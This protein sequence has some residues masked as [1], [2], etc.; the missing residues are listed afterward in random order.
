MELIF[1]FFKFLQQVWLGSICHFINSGAAGS[2]TF[3]GN[4]FVDWIDTYPKNYSVSFLGTTSEIGIRPYYKYGNAEHPVFYNTGGVRFGDDATDTTL[5]RER[6]TV[7][8][9]TTTVT[10][11]L[12]T[13][14]RIQIRDVNVVNTASIVTVGGG[15]VWINGAIN[16]S[17]A[18]MR[19]GEGSEGTMSYH[20]TGNVTLGTLTTFAD[21][22][23]ITFL[24]DVT[25]ETATTLLNTRVQFGD[26]ADDVATGSI[27]HRVD[28]RLTVTELVGMHV[29]IAEVLVEAHGDRPVVGIP[30]TRPE[31]GQRTDVGDA[32]HPR[33][34][35]TFVVSR[36]Q[37]LEHERVGHEGCRHVGG[38]D[39]GPTHV[40]TPLRRTTPIEMAV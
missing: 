3:N 37:G 28:V 33:G 40:E 5:I 4:L 19:F 12:R 2:V 21:D 27:E 29:Q 26:A 11:I 35:V 10:G 31:A 23:T 20:V 13:Y 16:G 15:T 39:G 7:A 8:T 17:G 6:L 1:I 34:M 22:T 32:R 30:V 14:Q 25:V 38:R 36:L 24:E 18:E 9:T